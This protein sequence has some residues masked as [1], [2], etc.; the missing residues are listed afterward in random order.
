METSHD[1]VDTIKAEKA[2]ALARY[3]MFSNTTK[4]FQLIELFVAVA[5]ISWSSTR[6]PL[7]IKFSSE[8]A[9]AFSSYFTNQ[10]VV[11]LV[12]NV[13]VVVC[14]MLSRDPDSSTELESGSQY[15]VVKYISND[16]TTSSQVTET[17]ETQIKRFQRTK[18]DKMKRRVPVKELRRSVTEMKRSED[19]RERSIQAVENLSN[20]EFQI[21]VEAFIK[22]QQRLLKEQSMD[23]EDS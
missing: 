12:G 23:G 2:N 20:E 3:R 19:S 10:H 4:F 8:Y 11:F 6:L 15:D 18:S 5:L 17:T 21:A 9:L 7:V 1:F 22:K 16:K 14:Y 13:I